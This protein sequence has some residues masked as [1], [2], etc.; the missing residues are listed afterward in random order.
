MSKT[1]MRYISETMNGCPYTDVDCI[2][3]CVAMDAK[4]SKAIEDYKA[5]QNEP[6]QVKEPGSPFSLDELK[7]DMMRQMIGD[8]KQTADIENYASGQPEVEPEVTEPK[9]YE[10]DREER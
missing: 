5:K 10:N 2:T 6:S 7:K 4:V 3:T 8:D 1:L 9:T